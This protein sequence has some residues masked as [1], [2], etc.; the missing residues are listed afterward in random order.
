MGLLEIAMV[1]GIACM[2]LFVAYILIKSGE[3]A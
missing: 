3:V 2:L 1:V